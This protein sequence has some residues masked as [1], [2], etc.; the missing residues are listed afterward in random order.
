MISSVSIGIGI[1]YAIHYISRY[2]WEAANGHDP[3]TALRQTSTSAG[4]AIIY[5]ALAL[6]V[7]F[8]VLVFSHFRAIAVFGLLISAAMIVSSLAALL[9]VP[10][11]LNH[12][13]KRQ[14]RKG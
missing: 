1:D 6:V 3:A 12:Y 8:L 14:L 11:L 10:L 2:R 7:G 4:R 9:V 5:N 13:A